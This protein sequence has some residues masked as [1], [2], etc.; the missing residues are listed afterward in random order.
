MLYNKLI[1]KILQTFDRSFLF[2]LNIVFTA[3]PY[4]YAIFLKPIMDRIDVA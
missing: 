2:F 3:K 4:Y 1:N